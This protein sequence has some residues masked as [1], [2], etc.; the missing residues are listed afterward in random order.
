MQNRPLLI[1]AIA[2]AFG[3][4]LFTLG[5]NNQFVIFCASAFVVGALLFTFKYKKYLPV[6]I[7][8]LFFILG[9]SIS[10]YRMQKFNNF[11]IPQNEKI[12]IVGTV[13]D[14]ILDQNKDSYQK[15]IISVTKINNIDKKCKIQLTV[16]QSNQTK[17]FNYGDEIYAICLNRQTTYKELLSYVISNNLS[18]QM[19]C[20][21]SQ[22][23]ITGNNVAS[24]N[25]NA[26]FFKIRNLST[27]TLSKLFDKDQAAVAQGITVGETSGYS[28]ELKDDFKNAGLS[29]ISAISGMQVTIVI[30]VLSYLLSA[31]FKKNSFLNIVL[32]LLII[33]FGFFVKWS[34]SVLRAVILS[35]V[36]L[37]AKI[38]WRRSDFLTSIG[39]AMLISLFINPFSIFNIGFMLSFAAV[40]GI[41]IFIVP[42]Y[43]TIK[44]S[45]YKLMNMV[46]P[47]IFVLITTSYITTVAFNSVNL[48]SLW[49]NVLILPLVDIASIG[50][51]A[52]LAVSSICFPLASFI[53]FSLRPII[54]AI[55]NL[56]S[57][58][59]NFTAVNINLPIPNFF[60]YIIYFSLLYLLY[61]IE[62]E[63]I[64]KWSNEQ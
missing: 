29:H 19:S 47:S 48:T 23:K 15:L 36:M 59:A 34:P 6:I 60:H 55:I 40:I 12:S 2:F 30:L 26:L 58:V 41:A 42:F 4:L 46:L 43:S 51:Y 33:M 5:L 8:V 53:A 14:V 13:H 38:F 32:M 52:I 45:K 54:W 27:Q 25:L 28:R 61:A 49:A 37:S 18:A 3:V 16:W 50:S 44:S 31:L 56:T 10:N 9:Y 11:N 57:I 62:K 63:V 22:I 24:P 35:I 39:I 17:S 64:N 7:C 21:G 20:D 1:S